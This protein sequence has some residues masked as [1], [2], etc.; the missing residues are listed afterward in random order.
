MKIINYTFSLKHKEYLSQ[1]LK[2]KIT[3]N[4]GQKFTRVSVEGDRVDFRGLK[5]SVLSFLSG[6]N[7]SMVVSS[8]SITFKNDTLKGKLSFWPLFTMAF[9]MSLLSV[10]MLH[11][12]FIFLLSTQG[13]VWL[14]FYGLNVWAR[15]YFF[16]KNIMGLLKADLPSRL[17]KAPPEQEEWIEN[18]DKCPACGH[19][20]NTDD[21]E[22]PDCGLNLD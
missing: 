4:I 18:P 22:C 12:D 9:F 20:L 8:G 2:D 10:A 19:P 21:N 11:N 7:L 14:W 13:L 15:G 3:E 16:Q 17:E 5:G 6:W 1:E